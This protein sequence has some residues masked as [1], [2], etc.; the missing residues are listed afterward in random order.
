MDKSKILI[1][2]DER[3][4]IDLLVELLAPQYH[5]IVARNGEQAIE[6]AAQKPK[7]DLI[8]LDV[9]LPGVDGYEVC[10]RLK[11]NI[12]T[13]EI[14]V[15]FLTVKSNVNDEIKGFELG[16]VDYI[17]KPISHPILLARVNTHITLKNALDATRKHANGLKVLIDEKTQELSKKDEEKQEAVEQ[18][19]FLANY[20]SLTRLPNRV[21]FKEQLTELCRQAL[22][23]NLLV[24]V[25]LIDLDHFKR[26][27][28]SMGHHIGDELLQMVALRIQNCLRKVDIMARL[29]GDEFTIALSD[30]RHR[31]NAAVVAQKIVST[32]NNPFD[33]EGNNV[34]ISASI[35]ITIFPDDNDDLDT[36]LQNADMAMYQAKKQGKDTFEFFTS[37]LTALAQKHIKLNDELRRAI[38]KYQFPT[39]LSAYHRTIDREI[40][41]SGGITKMEASYSG[42]HSTF[43]VFSYC[44]RKPD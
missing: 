35:G 26:V 34:H 28:D 20:D 38:S 12:A 11:K 42:H 4:Y 36:V 22:K 7:P 33:L 29:G 2:D 13:L 21:L 16:A 19:R 43:G 37:G 23:N 6:Y 44:R 39:L 3:F 18:L 40:S 30:L 15:I 31:D 25:L 41:R 24:G 14:P 17:Y 1:V 32:L 9:L 5:A 27:N 10:R 8:L